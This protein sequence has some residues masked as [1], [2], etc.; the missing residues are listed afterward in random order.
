[1]ARAALTVQEIDFDGLEPAYV[2][3]EGDGNS[4]ANT[5]EQF[6]HVKNGSGVSV[7]VTVQTPATVQGID[8]DEVEVAIAAGEERMIGPWPPAVYNQAGGLVYVDYSAVT[9]VT[10]GAF[11]L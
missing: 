2:A 8:I 5:G 11:K 1:M 6:V 10:V 3:A 9:T 7:T 4:V